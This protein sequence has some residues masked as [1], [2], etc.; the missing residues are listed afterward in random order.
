MV[1]ARGN[2]PRGPE[3]WERA[4]RYAITHPNTESA[5]LYFTRVENA[6][7]IATASENPL[8][9]YE[10]RNKRSME[11]RAYTTC[12]VFCT[13]MQVQLDH[14]GSLAEIR[15][16]FEGRTRWGRAVLALNTASLTRNVRCQVCGTTVK[17]TKKG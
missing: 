5:A 13:V 6:R 10:H 3:R 2:T 11:I 12:S 14:G 9:P 16:A 4:A 15:R 7:Q 8:Q 1:S 17:K